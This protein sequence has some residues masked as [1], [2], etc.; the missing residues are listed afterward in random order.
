MQNPSPHLP[1]SSSGSLTSSGKKKL[2]FWQRIGGGSLTISILIHAILLIVALLWVFQIVRPPEKTV[3]FMPASGGGG[4]PASESAASKHQ[5]RMSQPNLA[6]VAAVGATSN[7]VLP[8]PDELQSMTSMESLSSGGLS[9]GLG[10]KGSG[11]GRGDGF[12]KG[13]GSGMGAGLGGGSGMKNPF[14]AIDP[15]SDALVGTFYDLKQTKDRKP[16]GM[17]DTKMR[18]ELVEITRRGFKESVFEKYFK[19]PRKLYQTRFHIPVMSADS[20]PAAFEVQNDVQPRMWIVVYRGAVKAPKSGKFRFVGIGDDILVVRFNNRPVFDYGYTMSG[21][22]VHI[23]GRWGDVDGSND[24]PEI[25]K[26]VRRLTPMR[27]P[28]EFYKYATTPAHNN[29]VGGLAVGPEFEVE[30]GKVY[31]IEIMIGEIPGGAFALELLIQETGAS[32]QKDGSGNPILPLFRLDQTMPDAG[33][34]GA[35]PFATDGPIWPAAKG[36]ALLEI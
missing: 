14:G 35:A 2:P 6:R 12:G 10:G 21:T 16:T 26:D 32:Y 1:P 9:A 28:I 15:N 31:P 13:V 19:A 7:F 17:T 22:G 33:G 11:G 25:A 29:L 20:A 4:S 36:R 3:D 23:A 5:I 18:E 24:N 27:V 8:E 34:G 30:S